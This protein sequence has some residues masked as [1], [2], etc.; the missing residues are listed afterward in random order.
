LN[1]HDYGMFCYD[2]WDDV[3]EPVFSEREVTDENDGTSKKE[4]Y[5]TDERE[6]SVPAGEVYGIRY[7]E[8][9]CFIIAAL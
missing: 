4:R 8:L 1:P 9:L 7:D 5:Q 3:Y 2:S 6:I